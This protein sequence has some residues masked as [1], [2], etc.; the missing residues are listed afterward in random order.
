MIHGAP[1]A[2][3]PESAEKRAAVQRTPQVRCRFCP[4]VVDREPVAAAR[5]LLYGCKGATPAA[6]EAAAKVL[7]AERER[8]ER[9]AVEQA[10]RGGV[11]EEQ[12]PELLRKLRMQDYE[13]AGPP[14]ELR[15]D[16]TNA[17]SPRVFERHAARTKEKR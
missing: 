16:R 8:V 14:P 10:R 15:H 6:K 11:P 5:H 13:L 17:V 12:I 1:M 4:A 7:Q 2:R 9:A 3:E